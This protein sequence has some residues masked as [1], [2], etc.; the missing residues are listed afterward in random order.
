MNWRVGDESWGQIDRRERAA[1]KREKRLVTNSASG[2]QS[3]MNGAKIGL[4][5][6]KIDA[7]P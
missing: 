6:E 2:S 3:G 5:G 7:T 1:S 4:I